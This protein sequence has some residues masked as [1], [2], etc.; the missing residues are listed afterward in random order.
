MFARTV[1]YL[2]RGDVALRLG[3]CLLTAVVIC[4]ATRSWAPPFAYRTGFTPTRDILANFKLPNETATEEARREAQ[5]R[6]RYVYENDPK[7]LVQL[8][9]ALHN[10]VGEMLT[11]PAFNEEVERRWLEFLPRPA[12]GAPAPTREEQQQQYTRFKEALSGEGKLADYEKAVAEVFADFERQGLLEKLDQEPGEG[13]Q[14][15]ISVHPLGSKDWPQVVQVK[16]VRIADAIT[17]LR[18]RLKAK[19]ASPDVAERTY[20]W[21]AGQLPTTLKLDKD[22]TALEAAE[23]AEKTP[24]QTYPLGHT[25]AKAGQ[26]LT[27]EAVAAL[28]TEHALSVAS[29]SATQAVLRFGASVGMFVA[30]F[31]LCGFFIYRR[32]P[33]LLFDLRKFSTLLVVLTFS[34]LVA[35]VAAD[36]NWRA[37]MISVLVFG[38]TIAI[39]YR[40]ELALLLSAAVSLVVVVSL[41]QRLPD[42]VILMSSVAAAILCLGRVRNRSKLIHVGIY[43][44]MVAFLTTLGVGRLNEQPLAMPLLSDA[45][46]FGLWGVVAGFLMAGLLPNIESLFGILTDLRLLELGDPARPLLQEL[47]QRAPGT[48]NHSINV[49]SIAEAAAERIGARGLLVRVGAYYHDIGKMLKPHY[50]VE[51]QG[52]E[53]N[54]HE[55]LVPAM[56]TLIIIAHVKDGADLARQNNLP[57]PIV[58]FIQQHHGTTLV[59]Y[60]YRRACERDKDRDPDAPELSETSFRYPGPKPQTKE[61]A[62]LM[63]ADAVES[64]CRCLVEPTPSRIESVVDDIA[65]KRLLDGQFDDCDLTLCELRTIQDSLVKSL[66]AVYHGRVKY[67]ETQQRTA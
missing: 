42:Y 22:A 59:E 63:L 30:L 5:V 54:R 48:Y 18:E 19:L 60:F 43:A 29:L 3:L 27:P 21:L 31:T 66:I 36:D 58:D 56:S 64:A 50:F 52:Q 44:G 47:V 57:E 40:Q 2:R 20:N 26:P 13:N 4:I 1:E 24:V 37:E 41:G 39:A 38:M 49:A 51:N 32:E 15:E 9:A 61:A 35:T 10:R 34:V 62:V 8:R 67:P 25:I 17:P 11:A 55:A 16:D 33:R 65:M 46:R 53:A 6:I 12:E 7:P 14:V 45:A 28:R 23:A